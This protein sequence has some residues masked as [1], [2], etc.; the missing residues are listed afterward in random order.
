MPASTT[1]SARTLP[2]AVVT[3]GPGTVLDAG[4]L[5]ALVYGDT[6]PR[7]GPRLSQ[8]QVEGMQMAVAVVEQAAQV[9]IRAQQFG[10]LC[11]GHQ[12]H[13]AL[14]AAGAE[15]LMPSVSAVPGGAV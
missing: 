9:F 5:A 14:H 3:S 1:K 12:A 13:L 10:Q 11:A 8:A 7:G 4:D 6:E 15:R 2:W